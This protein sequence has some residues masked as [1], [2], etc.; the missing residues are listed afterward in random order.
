MFFHNAAE[1]LACLCLV[2]LVFVQQPCLFRHG[3]IRVFCLLQRVCLAVCGEVEVIG[4]AAYARQFKARYAE[5]SLR[6]SA[7]GRGVTYAQRTLFTHVYRFCGLFLPVVRAP[8]IVLLYGRFHQVQRCLGI[9]ML[10]IDVAFA[11]EAEGGDP[12]KSRLKPCNILVDVERSEVVT[13][14]VVTRLPLY[15]GCSEVSSCRHVAHC[16]SVVSVGEVGVYHFSAPRVVGKSLGQFIIAAALY[17]LL[18]AFGLLRSDRSTLYVHYALRFALQHLRHFRLIAHYIARK[19]LRSQC[20]YHHLAV[21][22]EAE[23]L[24]RAVVVAYHY[25][26]VAVGRE[27]GGYKVCLVAHQYFRPCRYEVRVVLVSVIFRAVARCLRVATHLYQRILPP[28][29]GAVS[30]VRQYGVPISVCRHPV[31]EVMVA[32]VERVRRR[33]PIEGA[34]ATFTLGHHQLVIGIRLA[35]RT[36]LLAALPLETYLLAVLPYIWCVE[37]RL[38][39]VVVVG[40]HSTYYEVEIWLVLCHIRSEIVGEELSRRLRLPC[41]SGVGGVGIRLV[42]V[43]QGGDGYALFLVSLYELVEIQAVGVVVSGI[44]HELVGGVWRCVN[45]ATVCSVVALRIVFVGLHPLRRAPRRSP[46][47]HVGVLFLRR[48][49]A[50]YN[51]FQVT[52]YGEVFHV[53]VFHVALRLVAAVPVTGIVGRTHWYAPHGQP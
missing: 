40:V 12:V 51:L 4:E 27:G 37:Y 23:C 6:P 44:V 32:E 9:Y 47:G 34:A 3:E 41:A 46:E 38:V 30:Q 35:Y 48:L 43:S 26:H 18:Q 22:V 29:P 2:S 8:Y 7:V 50:W 10:V 53:E 39:H 49:D 45:G 52:L 16:P 1:L 28:S 13:P 19:R 15:R 25:Y 20:A 11:A 17:R 14:V 24:L 5:P 31:G 33:I 36:Y 42:L 21:H